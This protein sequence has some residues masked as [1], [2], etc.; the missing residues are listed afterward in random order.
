MSEQVNKEQ[1]KGAE[2]ATITELSDE[3]LA[4]AKGGMQ[5]PGIVQTEQLSDMTTQAL[6]PRVAKIQPDALGNLPDVEK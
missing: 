1:T 6:G 4:E 2:Q 3:Q 5:H